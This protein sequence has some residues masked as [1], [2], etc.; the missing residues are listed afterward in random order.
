MSFRHHCL[1]QAH[2]EEEKQKQ[3][4]SDSSVQSIHWGQVEFSSG[5]SVQYSYTHKLTDT[6]S[7]QAGAHGTISERGEPSAEMDLFAL[8]KMSASTSLGMGVSF[9][10][11]GIAL[12]LSF[13]RDRQTISVPISLSEGFDLKVLAGATLIP[14]LIYACTRMFIVRPILKR[15]K[16]RELAI[17]RNKL[18]AKVQADQAAALADQE[19]MEH[20][21]QAKREEEERINGLIIV[22]AIYGNLNPDATVGPF[23]ADTPLPAID[24][25]T[26]MQNLVEYSKLQLH[27]YSKSKL[28]GFYDPCPFEEKTLRVV[29]NFKGRQHEVEVHDLDSLRIPQEEHLKPDEH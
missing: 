28:P 16:Q 10:S 11:E 18:K 12:K 7:V 29:Y 2:S 8:Q 21:V 24:V 14:S 23:D 13:S 4:H 9:G 17:R 27:S 26:P 19:F 20:A 3:A 5:T 22:N 1:K 15:R 25:T 6:V